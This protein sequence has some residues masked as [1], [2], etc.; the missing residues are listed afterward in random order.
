MVGK[1]QQGVGMVEAVMALAILAVA[2]NGLL[3]AQWQARQLQQAAT[4]R[5]LALQALQDF[6]ARW[7]LNPHGE[8]SY[9]SALSQAL[10]RPTTAD[11]C[12]LQACDADARARADV[13]SL[14]LQLRQ[15]LPQVQWRL[16]PCLDAPGSCLL[17]AWSGTHASSG[18]EGGCLDASGIRHAQANCSVLLLP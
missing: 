8:L 7:R 1:A 13:Q 17:V 10:P 15:D 18:P 4:T 3:A 2:L 11:T 16:E 5:L 9:R 14:A 12:Q 6:A